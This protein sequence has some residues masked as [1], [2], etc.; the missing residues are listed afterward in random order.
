[1][2]DQN[3]PQP[4]SS[5]QCRGPGCDRV[6]VRRAGM[7]PHRWA[8]LKTCSRSCGA[9]LGNAGRHGTQ[10]MV[11]HRCHL[12]DCKEEVPR[13]DGEPDSSYATRRYCSDAHRLIVVSRNLA[14]PPAAWRVERT[15]VCGATFLPQDKDQRFHDAACAAKNRK[16][17]TGRRIPTWKVERRCACGVRFVPRR[18][19]QAHHDPACRAKPAPEPELPVMVRVPRE[20][21]VW[22]PAS[23]GGPKTVVEY[24]LVEAT[25]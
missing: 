21:E 10:G 1:M 19:G 5:K 3:H 25:G 8:E 20:R 15:C 4:G 12:P 23:L 18:K 6:I 14:K 9:R 11:T 16:V 22:R 2:T 7:K 13:R 24:V 17:P